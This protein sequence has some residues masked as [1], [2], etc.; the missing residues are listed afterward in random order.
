MPKRPKV[1]LPPDV[2]AAETENAQSARLRELLWRCGMVDVPHHDKYHW[3]LLQ[4]AVVVGYRLE[5]AELAHIRAYEAE[6]VAQLERK[7]AKIE[8]AKAE[9]LGPRSC[10]AIRCEWLN[11]IGVHDATLAST[12]FVS[13]RT[14]ANYR[15]GKPITDRTRT[16][17]SNA[18]KRR[19]YPCKP[20]NLPA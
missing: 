8:R 11:W 13:K 3:T 2:L 19:G 10:A 14:M 6:I 5:P 15:S 12:G 4:A 7:V 18:L 17:I 1:Q 20:E 16:K 9:Q